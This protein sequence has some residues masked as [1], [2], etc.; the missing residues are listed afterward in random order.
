LQSCILS[1]VLAAE[2]GNGETAVILKSK[3]NKY[4]P[5]EGFYACCGGGL[6][7]KKNSDELL[8][9]ELTLTPCRSLY[10]N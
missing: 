9:K 2:H 1:L 4:A 6:R 5:A 3:V 10:S 8:I 7:D